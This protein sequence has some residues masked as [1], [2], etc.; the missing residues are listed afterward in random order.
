MISVVVFKNLIDI[1]ELFQY[2]MKYMRACVHACDSFDILLKVSVKNG[3]C[4]YNP[5]SIITL[6]F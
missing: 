5:S 6:H 2:L 4:S 1:S 3:K